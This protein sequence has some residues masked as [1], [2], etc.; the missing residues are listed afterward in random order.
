MES[1]SRKS[2]GSKKRDAS[3]DGWQMVFWRKGV[4]RPESSVKNGEIKGYSAQLDLLFN[5]NCER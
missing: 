2:P 4:R 3:F 5:W 1:Q